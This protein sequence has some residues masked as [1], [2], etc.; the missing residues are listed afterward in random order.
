MA[1]LAGF[2]AVKRLASRINI[3]ANENVSF[4][5]AELATIKNADFDHGYHLLSWNQKSPPPKRRA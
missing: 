5:I 1:D 2:I 4:A 3:F